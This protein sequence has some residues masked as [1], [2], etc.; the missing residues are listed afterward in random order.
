MSRTEPPRD[1]TISEFAR[2]I[3]ETRQ[4]LLSHHEP[5]EYHRCYTIR[6]DSRTVRLCARCSGIYPGLGIGL[7]AYGH[8]AGA[9]I[10]L[11]LVALLP[12]CA[13]AD[14]TVTAFTGL[15][16]YNS[17]RTLTGSLLG[18]AWG[19]GLARLVLSGD[20]VVVPVGLAYGSLAAL[21]LWIRE[22]GS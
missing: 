16:G 18:V 2:A 13:L 17:V 3:A 6:T 12:L 11:V 10:P 8:G 9:G 22:R 5:H 15:N 21:L 7:L 1:A 19:L 20:L 4:Y 14:W